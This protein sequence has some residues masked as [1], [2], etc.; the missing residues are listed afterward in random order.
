MTPEDTAPPSS[1]CRTL[2]AG[3]PTAEVSSVDADGSLVA[4]V[5][6]GV[7]AIIAAFGTYFCMYGFRKPFT[8]AGYAGGSWLGWDE[9]SVL[10][11]SQI[12]GYMVSKFIGIRVIS[13]MP[14]GRRVISLLSLI[15]IAELALIGFGSFPSPWQVIPLFVNGLM[16]GM[17]FGLVLGFL[18]GRRAT[19]ALTAGLCASFILA[20]GA[21]KSVGL[22]LLEQGVTERWMPAAAGGLF[23]LPLL[24]FAW[25]LSRIRP[26]SAADQQHRMPRHPMGP[27]QRS[28]FLARFGLPLAMLVL[29]YLLVTIV[30]SLRADFAPE[31]WRGLGVELV[32]S[33]F[34]IS[35]WWVGLGVFLVSGLG[36]LIQNNRRAL[37]TSLAVSAAG[38]LLMAAAVWLL[39]QQ[40]I[41]PL[42]F[43]IMLGIGLY[44]PYVAMHTAIFDRMIAVTRQPSNLGF[45]MYIADAFGYLGYVAVILGRHWLAELNDI[46][47]LVL[48]LGLVVG[49]VNLLLFGAAGLY[50]AALRVPPLPPPRSTA[51]VH[52]DVATNESA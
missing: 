18:E 43:M 15:G 24:L 33:T 22:W 12:L 35:E 1:R 52:S 17:V 48:W 13:Q 4:N 30:R 34:S 7:W 8:A 3:A 39:R 36:A 28:A 10:V 45:L 2:A 38:G 16:L 25:M 32:P 26:P 27:E 50:F 44:L 21:T 49:I 40:A 41:S 23:A 6:A 20:D 5:V 37:L 29:A 42:S 19:E 46:T 47:S 51:G 9:K 14:P 31:L 11:T